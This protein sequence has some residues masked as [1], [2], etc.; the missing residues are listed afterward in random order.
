MH[1]PHYPTREHTCTTLEVRFTWL[2]MWKRGGQGGWIRIGWERTTGVWT[3]HSSNRGQ[4]HYSTKLLRL[5]DFMLQQ[6]KCW[7]G[8]V[9][10][11]YECG[12]FSLYA[13]TLWQSGRNLPRG[14]TQNI[15]CDVFRSHRWQCFPTVTHRQKPVL[16]VTSIHLRNEMDVFM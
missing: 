5:N 1:Y 15:L 12:L 9:L 3:R 13:H 10:T 8:V 4:I 14:G 16:N 7:G 6:L 11:Y 2:Y